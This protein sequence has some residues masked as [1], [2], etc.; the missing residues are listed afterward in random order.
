MFASVQPQLYDV[1]VDD[2]EEVDLNLE[3]P[4]AARASS[5]PPEA[6]SSSSTYLPAVPRF[7]NDHIF[8]DMIDKLITHQNVY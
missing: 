6:Q 1:V 5:F 2:C 8:P 4:L 3:R 7:L